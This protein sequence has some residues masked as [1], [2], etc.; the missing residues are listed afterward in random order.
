MTVEDVG[1]IDPTAPKPMCRMSA[2]DVIAFK[3]TCG[4]FTVV[5]IQISKMNLRG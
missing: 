4:S 5:V 1:W 2:S 3:Q